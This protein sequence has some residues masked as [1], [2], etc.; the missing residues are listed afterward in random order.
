MNVNG[1]KGEVDGELDA[2][3][4]YVAGATA[5]GKLAQDFASEVEK[6]RAHKET[7][8]E[9]MTLLAA[10]LM[11]DKQIGYNKGLLDGEAR[12]EAKGQSILL[13]ALKMLKQHIPID[14]ICQEIGCSKKYLLELQA[15]EA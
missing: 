8:L 5:E 4:K 1:T 9:Y 10:E 15:L 11:R 13:Q 6:V 3:L 14:K 12:G 2:L 7:E